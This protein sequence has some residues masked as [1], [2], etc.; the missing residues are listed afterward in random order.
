M[1]ALCLP[2]STAHPAHPLVLA[3]AA[4]R[5]GNRRA[6]ALIGSSLFYAKDRSTLTMQPK[7]FAEV[8][9]CEVRSW[10]DEVTGHS[11]VLAVKLPV[12]NK[13]G[14][15]K[16]DAAPTFEM[17]L[18]AADSPREK[19]AGAVSHV[20]VAS[21]SSATRRRPAGTRGLTRSHAAVACRGARSSRWRQRS[22]FRCMAAARTRRLTRCC[23]Q[24]PTPRTSSRMAP[25]GCTASPARRSIGSAS[26]RTACRTLGARCRR[27]CQSHLRE[28]TSDIAA[29]IADFTGT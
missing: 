18:L 22:R 12:K 13:D 21:M 9:G 19:C 25:P 3:L 4:Q 10:T 1:C 15:G 23:R 11:N 28:Q 6:F 2:S 7:I 26:R 16:S 17:L 24:S 8:A 20:P 5:T 27:S 29:H 14:V